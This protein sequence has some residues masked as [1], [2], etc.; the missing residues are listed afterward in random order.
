MPRQP[1]KSGYTAAHA[2]SG[3]RGALPRLEV[4]PN[5]H[6]GYEIKTVIPEFTSICPKTGLPDFGQIILRYEPDETCIELKSLKYYIFGYRNLGIFYEN[7][8]NRILEDV[9]R[10]CRPKWAVVEGTFNT[11]GGMHTTVTAFHPKRRRPHSPAP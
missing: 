5:R 7:A 11:R 8:V 9:V 10:A 4:W 2:Q 1:K 3:A 6:R